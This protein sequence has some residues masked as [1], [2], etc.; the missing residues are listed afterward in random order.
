MSDTCTAT[1]MSDKAQNKWSN[2]QDFLGWVKRPV[3]PGYSFLSVIQSMVIMSMMDKGEGGDNAV[4]PLDLA[5]KE[6]VLHV[7]RGR[8]EGAM[9]RNML[10]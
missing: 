8:G 9:P 3:Q 10:W 5:L 6:R 7:S 4:A 1:L 2:V